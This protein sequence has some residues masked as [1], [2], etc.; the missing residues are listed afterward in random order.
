[1]RIYAS[2][3]DVSAII[4]SLRNCRVNC[5]M[6]M[7]LQNAV[8]NIY[9]MTEKIARR[10]VKNISYT[11]TPALAVVEKF[12]RRRAKMFLGTC[13]LALSVVKNLHVDVQKN[14]SAHVHLLSRW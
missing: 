8:S 7:A 5:D 1:M 9:V 13:T 6:T 3:V 14:F 10:R 12:A 11:C 2:R 4:E